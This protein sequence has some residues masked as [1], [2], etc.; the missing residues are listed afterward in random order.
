MI[1]AVQAATARTNGS[2]LNAHKSSRLPPPRPITSR[3]KHPSS[4]ASASM[5]AISAAA[6]APCTLAGSTTTRPRQPRRWR[7]RRKSRTAAPV[8]DVMN[9]TVAGIA[10]IGRFRSAANN[11]S[12]ASRRFNASNSRCSRPAPSSITARTMS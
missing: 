5:A 12:S 9:P 7:I 4:C 11:P 3:S 1:G 6:P 2:S 8:G 10:G